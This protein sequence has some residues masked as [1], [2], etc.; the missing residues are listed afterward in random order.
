MEHFCESYFKKTR[1]LFNKQIYN[2]LKLI[3]FVMVVLINGYYFARDRKIVVGGVAYRL[4]D[5]D[6]TPANQYTRKALFTFQFI[7]TGLSFLTLLIWSGIHF[8]IITANGWNKI[9]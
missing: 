2:L 6:D 4:L 7:Y 5:L 8:P 1:Y 9:F 3:C